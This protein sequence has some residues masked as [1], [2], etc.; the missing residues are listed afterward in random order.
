MTK[1]EFL[2]D[3]VKTLDPV[4]DGNEKFIESIKMVA[5]TAY[6]AGYVAGVQVGQ[7]AMMKATD[8]GYRAMFGKFKEVK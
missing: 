5:D 2:K 8:D 1:D 7:K 6:T 4:K 3:L